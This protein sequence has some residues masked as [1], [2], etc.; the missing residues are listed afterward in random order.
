MVLAPHP[1]DE[2]LATGGLLQQA[3]AVGAAVRVVFVTDG[4]NNP[5]P[6]RAIEH[7][8]RITAAD[9][10]RWGACRRGEALAALACLG[11]SA[12]CVVF[13]GYPDQGLPAL[14]RAGGEELPAT[15]AAEITA[16]RPTLLVTPSAFDRHPDHSALAALLGFALARLG[17]DQP[18]F[19]HISYLVH[20]RSDSYHW[21]HL[22]L[23]PEEQ[24]RKREAILCHAT[25][26]VLSKRRFLAFAAEVE[27]FI[28][29]AELIDCDE[30]RGAEFSVSR[31]PLSGVAI[32]TSYRAETRPEP[33]VC[34]VIPCYNV[35]ML[36]REVVR[37]AAQYADYVIAVNDGS[38][39]DTGETLRSVAA[40]SDGRV[41]VCSFAN[42]RGKGAALL[43][44][45][46]YAL[47]KFP[48]DVL[49]T[50]DGDCQ[51]RPADIPRLVQTWRNTHAALVIGE[52]L[53]F[54]AM[55]LR[56]RFGNTLTSAL[57][58][59]IYSAS[60]RDTQ[61]GLRALDRR[62]VTEVVRVIKG[63]RYETELSILLLALRQRRRIGTIPIPTV[64]L[65]GNRSSH[66]RPVADS[67]R[68]YQT[69]LS[70]CLLA[71]KE[72]LAMWRREK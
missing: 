19:T 14:V 5:W 27:K 12:D 64:Y 63:R 15:L 33:V 17:P 41:S 35:T 52:R 18:R 72:L 55:P 50:L 51:H 54:K 26:L 53:Q 59:Q 43:A 36:C 20:A 32:T 2:T 6:Q 37:E 11:V 65:A 1:D 16:W 66:F 70:G 34:C 58:R 60:P 39:D 10:V 46:R 49:I 69:L 48:F 44:G 30:V 56:S 22:C 25:Q 31:P 68:I 47:R 21:L 8:W 45:F 71:S 29:P 38:T 57:L 67:L 42:N 9:R 28:A 62:F 4:D 23:R 40:E 61:S 13:L 24:A 3:V 7:R